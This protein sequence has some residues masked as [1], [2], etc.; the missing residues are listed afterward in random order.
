MLCSFRRLRA[1][2]LLATCFFAAPLVWAQRAEL[3]PATP[4]RLPGTSDSNSPVVRRFGR[5]TIFQSYSLPLIVEGA[6]QIS[7]LRARPVLLNSFAHYPLW[8]ESTWMDEDGTL[9]AW[10]HHEQWMCGNGLAVPNI[11]ALVSRDGG[12][13]FQDLGIILESSYPV[14]CNAR[15]GF[16]AG[17][18][19]DF[20]VLLDSSRLYFYFYFTNYS[21]PLE[22]Q[23]VAV[24]RMPFAARAQ[25]VGQVRKFYQNNWAEPGIDG[26]VT[27]VL[28]ARA[29]WNRADMDSFWGP[30]L[31]WNTHLQQFVMLLNH[32]CCAP[33]WP[34]EGVYVS[35][36]PDLSIPTNWSVP[37]KLVD[38]DQARWYPQVIGRPPNGTDKN[39][40]RIARFY[41]GGDSDYEIIFDY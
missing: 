16:F 19:G 10:Y 27:A 40:G 36:N 32:A 17:G 31:H 14:D 33:G 5:F 18:H 23:G 3:R 37:Q 6:S 11:G 12:S 41:M 9:Y 24:A 7:P 20:T 13:T 26:R 29:S 34:Q 8:I 15:N 2:L 22:S 39:A 21:G 4:I 1:A 38:S 35:F 28:P 30:S 25:P